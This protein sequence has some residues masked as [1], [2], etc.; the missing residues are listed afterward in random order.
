[1]EL[2]APRDESGTP[3]AEPG[4]RLDRNRGCA[5]MTVSGADLS[6]DDTEGWK[7]NGQQVS[8]KAKAVTTNPAAPGMPSATTGTRPQHSEAFAKR[9]AARMSRA[10]RMPAIIPKLDVKIVMRPRGGLNIARVEANII[11]SAVLT[12]ARIPKTEAMADTICTNAT[13]NIIVAST[14]SEDRAR[15]YAAI[16]N[17]HIGG[18]NYELHAYRTAPYGTAKGIIRG[19]AVEDTDEELRNNIVNSANP[20]AL[21]VHRI[22]TTTTVIVLFAGQKVPNY[23]KYGSMLLKCSLYRQHYEVCRQCG[24]VGHR[25]DVCPFP[26][27]KVCFACGAPNPGPDHEMTCVPRCKLCNGPHPTGEAGCT[28]KYKVPYVVTRRRWERKHEAEKQKQSSLNSEDFPALPPP[29]TSAPER[30]RPRQRHL[31]SNRSIS[32]HRSASRQR[33][34]SRHRGTSGSDSQQR[35]VI[36]QGDRITWADTVKPP[37]KTP[38][39][40]RDT[41]TATAETL[42]LRTENE[43]LRR[44]LAAQ[45][46]RIAAQAATIEDINAKLERLLAVQTASTQ[47]KQTRG[48]STGGAAIITIEDETAAS[49]ESNRM[50]TERPQAE[51]EPGAAHTTEPASKRRALEVARERKTTARLDSQEDRLDRLENAVRATNERLATLGQTCQQMMETLVQMQAAIAGLST[52]AQHQQ[53]NQRPVWPEQQ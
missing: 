28:N 49:S 20:L 52:G 2:G 30:G 16:R 38:P 36:K 22:G 45:G 25:R 11:M 32:R 42:A 4:Y 5:I 15:L 43:H 44:Q 21:E 37:G 9:V 48:S 53:P 7:I 6:P 46:A 31:S 10:A 34:A 12:A 26:E 13:Q 50:D 29:Q 3:P 14:P 8:Q 35:K 19:I 27:T 18:K 17:L 39:H 23:V 51:V 40:G 47:Q 24:K 41:T 33:S 1:M